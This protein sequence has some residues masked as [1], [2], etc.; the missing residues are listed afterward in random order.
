VAPEIINIRD[1]KTKSDPICDVFSVGLIFHI[2]LM[3]KS[4][5]PG[6]TY[7]DVLNQNRACDFFIEAPEYQVISRPAHHLLKAMLEKDPRKRISSNDA[8][9]HPFFSEMEIERSMSPSHYV[10]AETP[11]KVTD[12]NKPAE[13]AWP[14]PKVSVFAHKEDMSVLSTIIINRRKYSKQ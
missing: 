2:L 14:S 12:E 1:M 11:L 10:Y 3:G 4:I 7:N 5:F 13:Y 9:K 6:K 8:L